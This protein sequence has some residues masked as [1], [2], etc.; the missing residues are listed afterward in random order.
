[1][2]GAA[3]LKRVEMRISIIAYSQQLGSIQVF[4]EWPFL[5]PPERGTELRVKDGS[6][7]DVRGEVNQIMAD[8]TDGTLHITLNRSL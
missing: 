8:L 2:H 1:M 5:F 3:K 7:N 6:G 4:A